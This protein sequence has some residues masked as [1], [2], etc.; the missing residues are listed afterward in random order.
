MNINEELNKKYLEYITMLDGLIKDS[1]NTLYE[2]FPLVLKEIINLTII[3]FAVFTIFFI[4][5]SLILIKLIRKCEKNGYTRV[6]TNWRGW[7]QEVFTRSSVWLMIVSVIW[8]ITTI[9][10]I[11]AFMCFLQAMVSPRLYIIKYMSKMLG[12]YL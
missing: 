3:N 8:T 6:I 4:I 12:I 10:G 11:D 2:Q 5:L 9:L 1:G 7:E